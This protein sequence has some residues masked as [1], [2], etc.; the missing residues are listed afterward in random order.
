MKQLD[1][2][3]ESRGKKSEAHQTLLRVKWDL[4][5][6]YLYMLCM[7]SSKKIVG[8]IFARSCFPIS[9]WCFTSKPEKKDLISVWRREKRKEEKGEQE[10]REKGKIWLQRSGHSRC[11]QS[12]P[13]EKKT[14]KKPRVD[15]WSGEKRSDVNNHRFPEGMGGRNF[16]E[17]YLRELSDDCPGMCLPRPFQKIKPGWAGRGLELTI[18][19]AMGNLIS[20]DPF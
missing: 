4:L 11:I 16:P 12:I 18:A 6:S 2:S 8:S 20:I 5:N 7:R 10:K 17:K 3:V 19:A 13:C 14:I 1:V 9:D 15:N